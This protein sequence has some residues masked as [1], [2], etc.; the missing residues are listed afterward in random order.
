MD[1]HDT[2]EPGFNEMLSSF[3]LSWL[4]HKQCWRVRSYEF[5]VI[6]GVPLINVALLKADAAL[7][8]GDPDERHPK[9]NSCASVP[10]H[11][12]CEALAGRP[13]DLDRQGLADICP[14]S[15]AHI[16]PTFLN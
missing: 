1:H 5:Q 13:H 10:L 2:L 4:F 7:I 3:P 9:G 16:E 6:H 14:V 15:C 8:V 12:T 11:R